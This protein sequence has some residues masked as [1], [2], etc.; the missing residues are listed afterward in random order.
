MKKYFNKFFEI[1]NWALISIIIACIVFGAFLSHQ[2]GDDYL[3]YN[4]I[5]GEPFFKALWYQYMTWDGRVLS[6]GGIARNFLILYTG[7]TFSI[8][9]FLIVYFLTCGVIS[10]FLK[11]FL[12]LK[13]SLR[14]N[15][16]I[17][18]VFMIGIWPVYKDIVYWQ[19]GGQYSF[20]VLQILVIIYL[21]GK[22]SVYQLEGNSSKYKALTIIICLVCSLNTQNLIFPVFV[23]FIAFLVYQFKFLNVNPSKAQY[24]SLVAIIIS[25]LIINL[26]PGN[27]TRLNLESKESFTLLQ[28]IINYLTILMRAANYS[29]IAM[30]G[31]LVLGLSFS[32]EETKRKIS[33]KNLILLG[34]AFLSMA[35]ISLAPFM[36]APVLA[37][38]RVFFS[39]MLFGFIATIF[40]G[41]LIGRVT[42]AKLD[43]IKRLSLPIFYLYGAIF[44][45]WQMS[46]LIP[47]SQE[48]HKREN[49]L[50]E[51]KDSNAI[52]I[53][54]S[55]PKPN[56]LLLIRSPIYAENNGWRKDLERFFGI[57]EYQEV[58]E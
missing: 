13:I 47:F 45:I 31:G 30:I 56:N 37:R 14:L 4:E 19:T 38:V 6:I 48:V 25:Q 52:V 1:T 21:V 8:I 43:P 24:I 44:F 54:K 20:W 22:E 2:Y 51:A 17:F 41:V 18:T 5:I 27:F 9:V 35:I 3:I 11:V 32:L 10:K 26:A 55:L 46:I 50:L 12:S 7:A 28:L 36:I 58:N 15:I 57:K 42:S 16:I 29:K 49:I 23:I 39:F 33:N 53:Y 34:I 40:I